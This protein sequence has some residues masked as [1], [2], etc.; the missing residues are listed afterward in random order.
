MERRARSGGSGSGRSP[1]PQAG[2]RARP[3]SP[4]RSKEVVVRIGCGDA[5][6]GRGMR[7]IAM[8]ADKGH[9]TR[10]GE[11]PMTGDATTTV[12]GLRQAP[13]SPRR[14]MPAGA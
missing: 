7:T 4:S 13:P 5:L 8:N 2:R 10:K 3:R 14:G 1:D 11:G 12:D 6:R 9:I